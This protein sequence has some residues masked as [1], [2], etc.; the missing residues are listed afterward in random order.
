MR[1]RNRKGGRQ[2]GSKLLREKAFDPTKPGMRE[3]RERKET[4]RKKK[5]RSVVPKG[6]KFESEK[7]LLKEWANF[8]CMAVRL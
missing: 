3:E 4:N 2:A 8:V 7:P 5:S 6:R 1:R